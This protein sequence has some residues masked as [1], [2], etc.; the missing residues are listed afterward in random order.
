MLQVP[1]TLDGLTPDGAVVVN[2]GRGKESADT[3]VEGHSAVHVPATGIAEQEI[4]RAIPNV[5]ML[6]AFLALT[7]LFPM[8]A[9]HRALGERFDAE[10]AKLNRQAADAAARLVNAGAWRELAYAH[11]D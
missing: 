1:A 11:V 8:E 7:E 3:T 6:G 2:S 4:G 5:P 10:T 9:L